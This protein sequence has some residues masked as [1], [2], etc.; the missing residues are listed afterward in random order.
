M[1][2][3]LL[4]SIWNIEFLV[5]IAEKIHKKLESKRKKRKKKETKGRKTESKARKKE[6]KKRKKEINKDKKRKKDR[7][8]KNVPC[9]HVYFSIIVINL[10]DYFSLQISL[11]NVYGC[12]L[13]SQTYVI[14]HN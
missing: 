9:V 14:Y 4:D 11:Y 7:K 1:H 8:K 3:V 10:I 12:Y 5:W 6:I 2:C 13:K